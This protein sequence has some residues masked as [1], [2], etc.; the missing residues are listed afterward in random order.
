MKYDLIV[1]GGG[2]AGLST[3]LHAKQRGLSTLILEKGSL[4]NSIRNFPQNMTF[5]STVEE[6][7]IGGIPFELRSPGDRSIGGRVLR[8]GAYV[9]KKDLHRMMTTLAKKKEVRLA[10]S[11]ADPGKSALNSPI[12]KRARA[13]VGSVTDSI[14]SRRPTRV[15][16]I[17]YYCKVADAHK[18]EIRGNSEVVSVRRTSNAT[19]C[20]A[21]EVRDTT[22]SGLSTVTG[23]KVVVA[24]GFYDNP[25]PMD[26]P[27]ENLPN[28]SHYYPGPVLGPDKRAVVIGGNHSA[29]DTALDLYRHGIGVTVLHRHDSFGKRIKPWILPEIKRRIGNGDITAHFNCRIVEILGDGVVIEKDGE[30]R[31]IKCDFVYAMTGYHPDFG[32]LRS[33]GIRIDEQT[34][35]PAHDPF[36]FESNV[37][38]IYL[39]GSITAGND[40]EKVF[41]DTGR[42]HGKAIVNNLL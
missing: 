3:A 25:S 10:A 22:T 20:F 2:P 19:G 13:L 17:D 26:V 4:V 14:P 18:V 32:F 27:G 36:T 8:R 34:G 41:I 37:P 29:V 6:L 33:M 12:L 42:M 23:D 16:A 5:F 24:T 1:I 9:L 39:A 11:S 15:E 35:V 28:V 38:G 40:L 31:T 30:K 21:L 7:E